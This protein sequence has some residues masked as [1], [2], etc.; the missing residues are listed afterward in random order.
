LALS[1][2]CESHDTSCNQVVAARV[3]IDASNWIFAQNQ[4]S[5]RKE[6]RYLLIIDDK[7][8]KLYKF[9]FDFVIWKPTEDIKHIVVNLW[10]WKCELVTLRV[11]AEIANQNIILEN[12]WGGLGCEFH[13]LGATNKKL[14]DRG[15]FGWMEVSVCSFPAVVSTRWVVGKSVRRFSEISRGIHRFVCEEW[16]VEEKWVFW[17]LT[18]CTVPL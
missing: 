3:A 7:H 13:H 15:Q 12:V 4:C 18:N 8:I 14:M 9:L 1:E 11:L 16:V 2:S 17:V 10:N 5:R 6:S